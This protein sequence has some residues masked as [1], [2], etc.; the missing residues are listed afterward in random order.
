MDARFAVLMVFALMVASCSPVAAPA[1]A[2]A[3]ATS[4]GVAAASPVP[5][6]TPEPQVLTIHNPAG[7]RADGVYVD[8]LLKKSMV[9]QKVTGPALAAEFPR[10]ATERITIKADASAEINDLFFKRGWGDGL[11]IVPPTE[12]RVMAMLAG[13]DLAP[14]WVVG[15]LQPMGGQATVA[16]IAVNAVMAGCRPEHMP[17]LIAAV[18][19]IQDAGFDQLGIAT[20]TN[21]DTH[22][23]IVSGPIVEQVGLNAGTSALG[24][25][26]RVNAP[27]GRAF[28][29]LIN[30][31]GG[32]WPGVSDMT[33]LGHPGDFAM[34]LAENGERS[35]WTPLHMDLGHPKDASVVT[36]LGVTGMQNIISIGMTNDEFLQKV[37][38]LITAGDK[39]FK[40]LQLLIIPP[41]VAIEMAKAGYTKDIIKGAVAERVGDPAFKDKLLVLVSGGPGEKN[42]LMPNWFNNTKPVSKAIRLPSNWAEL[43]KNAEE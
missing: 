40:N 33:A 7:M 43:L 15:E 36:V 41:D 19:A 39:R 29:M 16:K 34:C 35:P 38:D 2:A 12:E 17:I 22:M 26:S 18:E 1:P 24:R 10:S 25:G 3:T 9:E 23:L 8:E 28:H 21:P 4:A 42:M 13:T 20:T 14:D 5:S 6:A 31:V 32:A 11:P 30:N 27:I 37:A